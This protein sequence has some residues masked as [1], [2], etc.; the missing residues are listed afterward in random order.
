MQRRA[1]TLIE[2][3]VVIAIIAVLAAILFP[4]FAQS[5]EKARQAACMNNLRQ[6]GMAHIQYLQDYDE[7]YLPPPYINMIAGRATAAGPPELLFPYVKTRGVF[8]CPDEPDYLDL[9][10]F[11]E[12]PPSR[13]GCLGGRMGEWPGSV[14]YFSYSPNRAIFGRSQAQIPRTAETTVLFDGHGV[15]SG[16]PLTNVAVL[17]RPGKAPRHHEGLNA[18]YADGHAGYRKARFDPSFSFLGSPGW[19]LA[20]GGAY[21]GRPSLVGIVGEDGAL[22]P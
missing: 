4:V 8:Q 15:C 1:F 3:L 21:S 2:L 12:E 11:L 14:R 13:G 10:Q 9:K 19:W 7:T 6:L 22:L 16:S 20:A 18:A 5:R 17:A